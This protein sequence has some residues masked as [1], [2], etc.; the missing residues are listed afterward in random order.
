LESSLKFGSGI[1]PHQ[2]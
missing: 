2:M 1:F